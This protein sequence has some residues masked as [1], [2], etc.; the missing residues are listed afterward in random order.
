MTYAK[1]KKETPCSWGDH[2]PKASECPY[3]HTEEEKRVFARFP[4]T[5]TFQFFKTKECNKKY[6]H[7]TAEQRKSCRFAHDREDSW[8]LACQMYGHLTA[9]CLVKK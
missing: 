1:K 5:S 7:T 2:C 8:C 3:L 6:L 4:H 9:N